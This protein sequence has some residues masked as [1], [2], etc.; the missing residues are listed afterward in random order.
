[1]AMDIVQV[2]YIIVGVMMAFTALLVLV[3]IAGKDILMAFQRRFTPRGCEVF[4][5][6]T[7]RNLSNY[8][9][10]PKENKFR[11]GG[12]PYITNPEKIFNLSN[13]TK[14][15]VVD[16]IMRNRESIKKRLKELR[17]EKSSLEQHRKTLDNDNQKSIVDVKIISVED[18]MTELEN[19]K[20]VKQQNYFKDKRPAF[21]Y[22]EGDPVPKD[23]YQFTS[24]IDAKVMDNMMSRSI[25][26]P[27]DMK[28]EMDINFMKILLYMAIGAA[29]VAA[30]LAV[31][32]NTMLMELCRAAGL[33]CNM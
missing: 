28:K 23:L 31:R 27:K 32:N 25:T 12:L 18:N 20:L 24:N 22:I 17:D 5:A 14:L 33:V 9:L 29:G 10:T 2:M 11:I 1:M 13:D 6:G 3:I 21:M 4:V 7:N 30:I 19:R 15:Q 8:Y 16:S 26:E